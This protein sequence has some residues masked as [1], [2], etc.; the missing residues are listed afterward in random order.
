MCRN[1]LFAKNLKNDIS[2]LVLTFLTAVIS[3]FL[4]IIPT[5]FEMN[6]LHLEK[7]RLTAWIALIW[8]GLAGMGIASI[9]WFDGI[10]SASGS[11]AGGFMSVMYVSALL[12]SYVILSEQFMWIHMVGFILVFIGVILV[13]MSHAEEMEKVE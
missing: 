7:T 8:W 1:T 2:P 3:I 12:L 13:S 6:N 9:L 4:F 11:V 10:K 5:L